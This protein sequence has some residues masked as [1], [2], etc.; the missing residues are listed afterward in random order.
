M[1]TKK[2]NKPELTAYFSVLQSL[3][4]CFSTLFF[5][6]EV[7]AL[8][9]EVAALGAEVAALGAAAP[10]FSSCCSCDSVLPCA[11][12]AWYVDG[13]STCCKGLDI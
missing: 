12:L 10:E 6:A 7:A 3:C 9:V 8:G 1:V 11:G 4:K 13:P 2:M 5:D